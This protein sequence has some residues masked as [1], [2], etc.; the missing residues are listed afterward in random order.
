[1]KKK[2]RR[3]LTT[4]FALLFGVFAVFVG[5][6]VCSIS[7]TSYRSSMLE[8]YG[9]YAVGAAELAAAAL[10]PGELLRYA[11]ILRRDER[12][13]VIE[14][15]LDMIRKS[16]GIRYLYVQM[17]ISDKE[18]IYLFDIYDSEDSGGTD[19][20]LGARGAYNE[21]FRAAKHAM[22]TGKPER[23][24]DI[25]RS[26]HG[27]LASAYVPI[28]ADGVPF[29][30]VGADI[31]MNYIIGFLMR[32]LGVITLATAAVMAFCFTALFFLVHRSVLD[33]IKAVADKTGEFLQKV[34]DASFEGPRVHSNDEIGDLTTSVNRMFGDIRNFTSRLAE[35]TARRERIQSELD[36]AK[37][38]QE[39]VLPKIFPPFSN[40]QNVTAFASMT[41]A[42]EVGGDFYDF[43]IV[44]ES[45]LAVVIADV[46]DKGIP[47]ALFM[48][49]AKTL[50]KNRALS[51]DEPHK[52]L[53]IVNN[54]L[55]QNND[56][57]MFVTAFFGILDTKLGIL[58]YANAGHNPPIIL[59]GG[60]AHWVPVKRGL[61]LAAMEDVTFVTQEM[62]FEGD[63][64]LLLY[65]DGVT[66][67]MNVQAELFGQERLIALLSQLER[68]AAAPEKLIEA[69]EAAI[70][71]FAG[72]AEQTD[73]ITML[74]L[75]GNDAGS[76]SVGTG[77]T[78]NGR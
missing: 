39:G 12:Y 50:I 74:A 67:A 71:H 29:A 68:Q 31:S 26:E 19:T 4:K 65:T 42:K 32:Y 63:D 75:R 46:S 55:C 1:M 18:F 20:S 11:K 72:D 28:S 66:E 13:G 61:A 3:T 47:A 37:D 15:E 6:L 14:K 77:G 35:E 41:P 24:L 58:R 17:P 10:D 33:P 49:V 53:E 73:D 54:Q 45:R 48:M 25:T 76:M 22:S 30:Y 40:F 69:V 21:N 70:R 2:A 51:G 52:V 7:Y 9:R 38:I 8:H 64:V 59:R 34:N 57:G 43:F 78:Y 44:G 23:E 62:R 56:A 5:A 60:E 27:Y 16:L 36:M